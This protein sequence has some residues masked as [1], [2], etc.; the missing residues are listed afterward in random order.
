[1]KKLGT[2]LA[3]F[4]LMAFA[5]FGVNANTAI[6]DSVEWQ[7]VIRQRSNSSDDSISNAVVVSVSG[8]VSGDITIPSSLGG[9]PVRTIQGSAFANLTGMTS[10]RIPGTVTSFGSKAFEGCTSLTAV[11][12]EDMAAWCGVK[13]VYNINP[14]NVSSNPLN[15]SQHLYFN[16]ELVT[17]VVVPEGVTSIGNGFY[18]YTNLTSVVIPDSCTK[19]EPCAFSGCTSLRSAYIGDGVTSLDESLFSH[20]TGLTDLRIGTNVNSI[21]SYT[22]GGTFAGCT[23]LRCVVIPSSVKRIGGSAFSSCSSLTNA[24]LQSGLEKIGDLTFAYA[25][26]MQIE[27]PDTVASIGNSAF[28]GNVRL[29]SAILS[30]GVSKIENYAFMECPNLK[31]VTIPSSVKRIGEKAFYECDKLSRVDIDDFASWCQIQYCNSADSSQHYEDESKNYASVVGNPLRNGPELYVA[32]VAVGKTLD[33]PYGVTNIAPYAFCGWTNVVNIQIA[34]SVKDIGT[35]AFDRCLNLRKV[36]MGKGVERIRS[37]LFED[38]S[39]LYDIV[40]SPNATAIGNNVCY[41]C[42]SLGEVFIP[43][44]V[45]SLGSYA[46]RSCTNLVKVVF[47]GD[48]PIITSSSFGDVKA[49]C[50]AYVPWLSV[51]WN[52]AIPGTWNG[53]N[54][55]YLFTGNNEVEEPEELPETI[56]IQSDAEV[57]VRGS[58]TP[59]ELKAQLLA[60]LARVEAMGRGVGQDPAC[61]KVVGRCDEANGTITLKAVLDAERLGLSETLASVLAPDT[62][63]AFQADG[64]IRLTNVKDGFYYGVAAAE[65]L[66]ELDAAADAVRTNGLTRAENGEVIL[67]SR[68]PTGK[69]MF[70]R[71]FANDSGQ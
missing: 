41:G 58:P 6:I 4:V 22:Y 42:R 18:G 23:N 39:S 68:R 33:I 8:D 16:G 26:L 60:L 66:E 36:V 1:M 20:C 7:Y 37:S 69:S 48:A 10:I 55:A 15:L 31:R 49:G 35:H 63:A 17:D 67:S 64:T 50:T 21:W 27:I 29:E 45:E 30:E 71:V 9:W 61:F 19:I 32:G 52:V 43:S 5:A 11:Y 47:A 51:G 54:I 44:S 65:R 59:A 57:T 14:W 34:D 62:L 70:F 12:I 46:F 38:C 25:G 13:F 53:I 28:R 24:V 40:F 3:V 56:V 2:R